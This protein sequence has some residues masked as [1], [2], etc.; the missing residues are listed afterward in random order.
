ME[1]DAFKKELF[2]IALRKGG[3]FI[4]IAAMLAVLIVVPTKTVVVLSL[5]ALFL[6]FIRAFLFYYKSNLVVHEE[7]AEKYGDEY[8][9]VFKDAYEKQGLSELV[10]IEWFKKQTNRKQEKADQ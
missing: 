6:S 1:K 7:M 4:W 8:L 9:D 2:F 3:I 5:F 10:R